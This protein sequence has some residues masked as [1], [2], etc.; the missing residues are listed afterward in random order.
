NARIGHVP[1]ETR[2]TGGRVF[3]TGDCHEVSRSIGDASGSAPSKSGRHSQLELLDGVGSHVPND[4]MEV[5]TAGR[6][7]PHHLPRTVDSPPHSGVPAAPIGYR[8]QHIF[9]FLVDKG[10][11][12]S[13]IGEPAD[14]VASVIESRRRADKNLPQ[15]EPLDRKHRAGGTSRLVWVPKE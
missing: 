12:S 4:G 9:V 2:G 7:F 3:G 15:I 14:N 1:E 10:P 5:F 6:H 13:R 11:D 8:Q